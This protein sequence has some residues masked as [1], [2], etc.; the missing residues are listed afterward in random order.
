MGLLGGI[1]LLDLFDRIADPKKKERDRLVD[2]GSF[3][4]K[5][6]KPAPKNIFDF[7]DP[8]F[9]RKRGRFL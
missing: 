8:A 6:A 9:Q 1:F 4:G 2:V 5:P 7:R 3:L